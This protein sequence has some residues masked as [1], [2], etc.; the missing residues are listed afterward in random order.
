MVTS[1]GSPV[2]PQQE[3]VLRVCLAEMSKQENVSEDLVSDYICQGDYSKYFP[4]FLIQQLKSN[5][6]SQ[7]FGLVASQT[8]EL[9]SSVVPLS[10]GS[11]A[12][13]SVVFLS[14][15]GGALRGE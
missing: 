15:L 1:Y 3:N 10:Q 11:R 14:L 6:L 2:L 13:A 4:H 7:V 12:S 9:G 5:S 8:S